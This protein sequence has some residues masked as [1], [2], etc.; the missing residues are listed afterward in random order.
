[1][2]ENCCVCGLI[3]G[4]NYPK[5]KFGDGKPFI[6]LEGC[7]DIIIVDRR[8]FLNNYQLIK[9]WAETRKEVKLYGQTNDNQIAVHDS[10]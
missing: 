1:M 8:Y 6:D 3:E 10:L 4:Y 5:D 9:R 7:R 2:T